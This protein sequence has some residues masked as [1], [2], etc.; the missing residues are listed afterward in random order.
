MIERKQ[1][2]NWESKL[3]VKK[4]NCFCGKNENKKVRKKIICF[5]RKIVRNKERKKEVI[6]FFGV[7][8]W[9]E[10][11]LFVNLYGWNEIKMYYK[12]ELL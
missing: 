8:I 6:F 12:K 3:F 9:N 10:R 7:L 4:I 1:L 5:C 2:F 11:E